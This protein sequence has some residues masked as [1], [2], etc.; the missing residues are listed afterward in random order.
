MFGMGGWEEAKKSPK[1]MSLGEGK[2]HPIFVIRGDKTS[3]FG[4]RFRVGFLVSVLKN[5]YFFFIR[6]FGAHDILG[7]V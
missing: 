1:F 4:F 2:F 6:A 5:F 3:D 7:E